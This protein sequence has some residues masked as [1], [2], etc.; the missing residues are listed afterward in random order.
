MYSSFAAQRSLRKQR[1]IERACGSNQYFLWTRACNVRRNTFRRQLLSPY[2]I[3]YQP[4]RQTSVLLR[5]RLSISNRKGSLHSLCTCHCQK[6][7]VG[8][9]QQ[10]SITP[11]GASALTWPTVSQDYFSCTLATTGKR[12]SKRRPLR[13]PIS[14]LTHQVQSGISILLRC[15][16]ASCVFWLPPHP[17]NQTKSF[18]APSTCCSNTKSLKHTY[19]Q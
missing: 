15:F 9:Q 3:N 5:V 2:R 17:E 6:G 13:L 12:R 8:V 7:L 16:T 4:L 19:I 14:G 11:A 10:Q 18:T 1:Q